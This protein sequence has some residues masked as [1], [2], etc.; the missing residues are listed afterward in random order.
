MAPISPV[1]WGFT[2]TPWRDG[3]LVEREQTEQEGWVGERRVANDK[4]GFPQGPAQAPG[5][6]APYLRKGI[7]KSGGGV[8]S[9]EV[10]AEIGAQETWGYGSPVRS[11]GQNQ[12]S[13]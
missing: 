3:L 1:L 7:N 11:E 5:V 12:N 8:A 13:S 4:A 10:P 6:S 2:D 9:M